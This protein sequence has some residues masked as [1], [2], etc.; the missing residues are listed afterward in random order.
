[1]LFEMAFLSPSLPSFFLPS[2]WLHLLHVEVQG[3]GLNLHTN[4]QSHSS[5][6]DRSLNHCTTRDFSW[7]DFSNKPFPDFL[8]FPFKEFTS[9]GISW[10][11]F[12]F[13]QGIHNAEKLLSEIIH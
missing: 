7:S 8:V 4:D 10:M 5:E 2:S 12:F 13:A 3:Q 11:F 6:N 9:D 1:M